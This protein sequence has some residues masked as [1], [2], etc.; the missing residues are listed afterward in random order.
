MAPHSGFRTIAKIA[1]CR[2]AAQAVV[3]ATLAAH[4]SGVA[5]FSFGGAGRPQS[6]RSRPASLGRGCV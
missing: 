6:R 1:F 2:G 4:G 3:T 5:R